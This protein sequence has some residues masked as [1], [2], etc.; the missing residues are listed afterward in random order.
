MKVV[1]LVSGGKDSCYN[2]ML[3]ESFGHQVVA[4]ANLMPMDECIDDLDSYMFQTVGHQLIGF[5]SQ[6]MGLPLYRKK[7]RGTSIH[8]GLAYDATD[9]DE[10]EDMMDLLAYVKA[11]NPEVDAVSS[12]AIASDYQRLRVEHVCSRLGLTSLAYMWRLPQVD[13]FKGMMEQSVDAVLVKVASLGLT[14]NEHLGKRL[15]EVRDVLFRLREIYASSVCGEGGE[16]E[17]VVL[18]CPLFKFGRI[19]LDKHTIVTTS[20]D[21]VAPAG[22][23]H[24]TEF[25]VEKKQAASEFP[26]SPSIVDVDEN[27]L[28]SCMNCCCDATLQHTN[29]DK[30][31]QGVATLKAYRSD[32]YVHIMSEGYLKADADP[33]IHPP[34][35]SE[36]IKS[37]MRSMLSSVQCEL[38]ESIL[39]W[40]NCVFVHLYLSDMSS[41]ADANS[42]YCEFF[43]LVNPPSRA[44]VELPLPPGVLCKLDVLAYS[45][46]KVVDGRPRR[47]LH[48]QSRSQWA[49]C[50]IGPYSQATSCGAVLHMAGQLGFTPP[51][52]NLVPGGFQAQFQAALDHCQSVAVAMGSDVRKAALGYINY[53]SKAACDDP[54]YSS[55]AHESFMAFCPNAVLWEDDKCVVQSEQSDADFDS[56]LL[57][58]AIPCGIPP[59]IIYLCVPA[60]PK[61]GLVEVQPLAFDARKVHIWDGS[62]SDESEDTSTLSPVGRKDGSG[63]DMNVI[64][65]CKQGLTFWTG[66]TVLC[67]S[68]IEISGGLVSVTTIASRLALWL[69]TCVTIEDAPELGRCIFNII[70]IF[71]DQCELHW[72]DICM[73]RFACVE[74]RMSLMEKIVCNLRQSAIDAGCGDIEGVTVPV[75]KLGPKPSMDKMALVEVVA[76]GAWGK[77]DTSL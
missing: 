74:N 60:L 23:L 16:Y 52:M 69:P 4:L 19:V 48:V 54:S 67:R 25:H 38:E 51:T 65:S 50:C 20:Q 27:S 7:I 53:I 22:L 56:Y 75:I 71:V 42:V 28:R 24:A 3:C 72:H 61:G 41:F 30:R 11:V 77:P 36:N 15:N 29:E 49:P 9:D 35:S 33:S 40:D 76:G 55:I 59:I 63:V 73:Y 45:H 1:A 57:P 8:R 14:P 32:C 64:S 62:V 47:V 31:G 37:C 34:T 44:C 12:G 21:A 2:M 68:G 43:P 18:D 46:P 66:F 17:T 13:L 26:S 70:A 5:F 6:C 58:P 39:S 10:V